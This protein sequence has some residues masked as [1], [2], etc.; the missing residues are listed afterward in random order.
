MTHTLTVSP[1][2]TSTKTPTSTPPHTQTGTDTHTPTNTRTETMTETPTI[3]PTFTFTHTDTH[4]PTLSPTFTSTKTETHTPTLTN[5]PFMT[6]T[7]TAT[8]TAT[9]TKTTTFTPTQT[10][11]PAFTITNTYT[12]TPSITPTFTF[13][14]TPTFTPTSTYTTTPTYSYTPTV[15]NTY[16]FTLTPTSTATA[17]LGLVK[18]SSEHQ[19]SPLDIITYTLTYSNPGSSPV[20]NPVLVDNLP[21]TSEMQY[22]ASS[23]S[24][25]GTYNIANNTLNWTLATVAPGQVVNVTYQ[26]QASLVSATAKTNILVNNAQLTYAGGTAS[27]TNSVTVTGSYVIH[28][29]VYNSAGELMKDY[30][31]FELNSSISNFTIVNGN[32]TTDSQSVSILYDNLNVGTWD[33]TTNSGDKV[34]NGTYIIKI[35]STDPF[36]VTTSVSKD[37]SVLIG[38]NVLSAT[39]FNEAGEAVKHFDQAE[40]QALVAGSSSSLQASDYDVAQIR[41]ANNVIQPD[42][43]GATSGSKVLTI[44]MGSGRTFTY[45][46]IADNGAILMPGT[47]YIQFESQVQGQPDQEISLTF[48]VEGGANGIGGVV[49]APNPIRVSQLTQIPY[50]I[51]NTG[52]ANVTATTVRIYTVAGELVKNNLTND[53]GNP[54]VVHWDVAQENIASGTYLAVIELHSNNGVIGHKIM[55]VLVIR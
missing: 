13:T 48:R 55:K 11:S 25:G 5:T 34:S 47:Y 29:A 9:P 6:S 52:A 33:A 44:T 4:T 36:G 54:G 38:R 40:L 19:A 42:Y 28:L 7:P 39:V 37:V 46:G 17:V 35:D 27:A 8:L 43:S 50:F 12:W 18:N 24:M 16:T 2:P 15:T 26:I 45:N 23:A 31:A 3:S 51:I 22:V 53:S 14:Y 21:P 1:T 41:L 49:L 30:P 32:I 20:I 10:F